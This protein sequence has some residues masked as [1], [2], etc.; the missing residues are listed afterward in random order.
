[1]S[2]DITMKIVDK[3][4]K[5]VVNNICEG[6]RNRIWFDNLSHCSDRLYENFPVKYGLIDKLDDVENTLKVAGHYDFRY[7]SL[8]DFLNW[9]NKTKPEIIAAWVRKYDAFLYT[10]KGIPVEDYSLYLPDDARIEDFV[11]LEFQR[12]DDFCYLIYKDIVSNLNISSLNLEEYY[13][14]YYFDC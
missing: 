2:V 8:K 7:I 13:L 5:T 11:W 14:I 6:I 1:M 3:N 10:N 4:G 12:S 9:Y